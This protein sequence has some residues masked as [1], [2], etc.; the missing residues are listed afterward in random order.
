MTVK[1]DFI[2]ILT[3][4]YSTNMNSYH[5]VTRPTRKERAREFRELVER[6]WQSK[7]LEFI[8]PYMT[9]PLF[10]WYTFSENPNLN[11]QFI[12][13]N[14]QYPWQLDRVCRRLDIPIETVIGRFG[15]LGEEVWINLMTR[16]DMTI[17]FIEDH[18]EYPWL[19]SHMILLKKKVTLDF[20]KKHEDDVLWW[21]QLH[22]NDTY[23][24][25]EFITTFPNH[26]DEET[27]SAYTGMTSELVMQADDELV[28]AL[29][30]Q[31]TCPNITEMVYKYPNAKW[32]WTEIS[33]N[34]HVTAPFIKKYRA[35]LD[36]KFLTC[37]IDKKIIKA[38]PKLPWD[39]KVYHF[40]N[41]I[42][43]RELFEH[44]MDYTDDIGLGAHSEIRFRDISND[45]IIKWNINSITWN[46]FE[47]ERRD[48][49]V[50]KYREYLA[51][52]RIQQYYNL[53]ASA[54]VYSTCRKRIALDYDREF[55]QSNEPDC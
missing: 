48:F 46:T 35:K 34:P 14:P 40:R 23:T 50:R 7:Y 38:N 4:W 2:N 39:Y 51:T 31:R 49:F 8:R 28:N 13:D 54:P 15:H 42:S 30:H 45:K 26:V 10:N 21:Y 5:Q 36:W 27:I 33:F 11:P 3:K 6:E 24:I 44:I 53:V 43:H 22:F 19:Y 32:D 52:Y 55:G 29:C 20:L 18:P 1:I 37:V 16:D 47:G 17:E 41:D 12:F 25:K 9:N